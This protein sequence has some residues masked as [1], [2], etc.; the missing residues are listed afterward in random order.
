M[1]E[2]QRCSVTATLNS[3][4]SAHPVQQTKNRLVYDEQ[5]GMFSFI[6]IPLHPH[7]KPPRL[8][9]YSHPDFHGRLFL[10]QPADTALVLGHLLRAVRVRECFNSHRKVITRNGLN[11]NNSIA[12]S[13]FLVQQTE[14]CRHLL[15]ENRRLHGTIHN[16]ET[17]E[18]LE[19]HF[20]SDRGP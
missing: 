5:N 6:L 19:G 18:V 1:G 10:Y 11:N 16:S 20:I 12:S 8:F 7:W 3:A 9:P 2:T 13:F 17:V 14:S 15:N 4:I